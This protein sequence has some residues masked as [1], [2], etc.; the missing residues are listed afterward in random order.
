MKKLMLLA[1]LLCSFGCGG[2]C[3]DPVNRDGG[4]PWHK[5]AN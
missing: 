1:V 3:V 4:P 5:S 2:T